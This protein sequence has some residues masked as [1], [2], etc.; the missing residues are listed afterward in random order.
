MST[1]TGLLQRWQRVRVV[2][3]SPLADLTADALA[4]VDSDCRPLPYFGAESSFR[5]DLRAPNIHCCL[6]Q[7][8]ATDVHEQKNDHETKR[9]KQDRG[10]GLVIGNEAIAFQCRWKQTEDWA[11]LAS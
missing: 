2:V 8:S 9:A 5:R 7:H 3:R 11:A 6:G 4:E 1:V 10:R